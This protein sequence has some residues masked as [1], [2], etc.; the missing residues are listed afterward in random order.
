MRCGVDIIE[1]QRVSRAYHKRPRLFLK[2]LFTERE[3][4]QLAAR[5]HAGKHLAV[6]FAGKEAVFK[7]LGVG[8]GSIAWTDV[9]ILS[10]PSGEPVV[11]LHG[12]AAQRAEELG[13]K[14]I[15]LSLSHCREYAVA[16]VVAT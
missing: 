11:S 10:L 9:E 6:R 12:K 8:Q 15:V 2:R 13:L 4:R 3:V 16:Q 7:A 14:E 1:I 5:F